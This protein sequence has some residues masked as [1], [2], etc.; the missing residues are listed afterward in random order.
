[1][2]ENSGTVQ[3]KKI[4]ELTEV[5]DDRNGHGRRATDGKNSQQI[6][7]IDGRGYE[8]VK[9]SGESIHELTDVIDDN[10]LTP[11]IKEVIMSRAEEVI[12]QIAREV[13][14]DIAERVIR[15]EIK[16]IKDKNAGHSSKRD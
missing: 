3:G 14:P 11:Q 15:E 1:M 8:R 12:K 4:H 16:K 10:L 7:A 2:G 5:Y 9:V 13:I 6:I